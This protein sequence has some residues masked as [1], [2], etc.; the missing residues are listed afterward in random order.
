MLKLITISRTENRIIIKFGEGAVLSFKY[1]YRIYDIINKVL[2][3][4]NIPQ[5]KRL[6]I[7][8]FF[9]SESAYIYNIYNHKYTPEEIFNLLENK[10]LYPTNIY[11]I[12]ETIDYVIKNKISVSRIGDGEELLYNML[13]VKCLFPELRN[14]LLSICASGSDDNCLVCINNFNVDDIKVENF[15]RKAFTL[16]WAN[17]VKADA[18]KNIRFSKKSYYGDAYAFLFYFNNTDKEE[19]ELKKRKIEK[20]WENR[21]VL[22]IINKNSG[23]LKDSE[24]FINVKEKA[25]MFGPAKNAFSDY[26]R[27]LKEISSNYSTDWLIYIEMGAMATVLSYDLSRI[28]YQA[29]DMGAFYSRIYR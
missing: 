18:F 29:L 19:Y 10:K 20:L 2:K 4:F 1:K 15:Y 16:Y 23:I 21:K 17:I 7:L 8:R 5:I 14:K 28:G 11:S 12:D 9:D 26:D 25:F 24:C 27:I 6:V 13:G 3:L 22:F